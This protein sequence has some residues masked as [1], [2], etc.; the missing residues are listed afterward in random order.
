MST[1]SGTTLD[2]H[3]LGVYLHDHLA[4]AAG[5]V[6]L[7]RH[8]AKEQADT[9]A[10]PVLAALAHE[11][12]RDRDSLRTILD[13]LGMTD[14]AV[15]EAAT[16]LGEKVA[17]LKPNGQLVGRSPLTSLIEIETLRIALVGKLAGWTTLRTLA[18]DDPRLDADHLDRLIVRGIEQADIA[19]ELRKSMASKVFLVPQEA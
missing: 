16:W 8:A 13:D 4:G 12:E 9:P 1:A 11:I 18:D 17:R 3:L 15:H 6:E 2:D 7:V 10:G 5:G 14:F 19:E